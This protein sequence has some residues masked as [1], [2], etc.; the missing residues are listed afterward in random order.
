M[1]AKLIGERSAGMTAVE[2]YNDVNTDLVWSYRW[3]ADGATTSSYIAELCD[4]Y[5]CMRQ[6][7][8]VADFDRGGVDDDGAPIVM[9]DGDTTGV[10]LEYSAATGWVLGDDARRMGQSSEIIDA[11]MLAGLLEPDDEHAA[12]VVDDVVV[13]IAAHLLRA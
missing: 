3:F 11:C 5:D 7:D 8:N 6:C 13:A 9:D 12:H 1:R 4:A 2:V 10:M